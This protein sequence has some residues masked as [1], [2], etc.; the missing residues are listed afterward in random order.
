MAY[1]GNTANTQFDFN[2]IQELLITQ[3]KKSRQQFPEHIYVLPAISDNVEFQLEQ[4]LQ[5]EREDHTGKRIILIPYYLEKSHWVGILVEFQ[6]DEKIQRA[7]YINPVNGPNV[8]P[9]R[10]QKQFVKVYRYAILQPRDLFKHNDRGLSSALTIKNL[11]AAAANDQHSD[12]I[13]QEVSQLYSMIPDENKT[14]TYST[15][16]E[17]LNSPKKDNTIPTSTTHIPNEGNRYKLQELEQKFHSGLTK[18]KIKDAVMLSKEIQKTS[19]LID[20][21]EEEEKTEDMKREVNSLS[22]LEQLRNL[23]DEINILKCASPNPSPNDKPKVYEL[24]EKLNR[25]LAKINLHNMDDLVE[26]IR[27]TEKRIQIFERKGRKEKAQEEM[28]FLEELQELKELSDRITKLNINAPVSSVGHE[29]ELSELRERLNSGLAKIKLQNV[30]ELPG[31][32]KDT[33]ERVQK[34]EKR[35][36]KEKALEETEFLR[37]LGELKEILD[38][39]TKLL[40]NTPAFAPD[41]QLKHREQHDEFDSKSLKNN[42]QNT[43]EY[44]STSIPPA[45]D[46][47]EPFTVRSQWGTPTSTDRSTTTLD[48]QKK[49]LLYIKELRNEADAMPTCARKTTIE[50]LVYFEQKLLGEST[51]AHNEDTVISLLQKLKDQVKKEELLSE[52]VKSVLHDLEMYITNDN[53]SVVVRYLNELLKKF[54]SLNVPEIQRLVAK[55]KEAAE[56]IHNQDVILLIGTTGAGK[57]T[58]VQFLAGAT[59][60]EVRVEISPGKYLEHVTAVGPIKNPDLNNVNSSPL[61]KSETRYIAPVT[62]QLKDILG[63]HETGIITLYDAPGFDDKAGPEVDIA[64]SIGVIEALKG[65]KSVKLLVLSSYQSLGDRGQGIQKLAHILISMVHGIQD[66]LDAIFYAFTKYP[67]TTDI[68][69]LLLDIKRSKVDEDVTLRSDTAFVTVLSDM[70]EKTEDSAYKIE[71][72]RDEPKKLIEKLK[73]IRGIRNPEEVFRFSMSEETRASIVDHIQR[74]KF[75]IICAMKYKDNDL[76]LYY[77][78]DLQ[79]LKDLIKESFIRHT[80]EESVRFVSENISKHCTEIMEKFNRAL[81]SQDGLQ[82]KDILDYQ[83]SIKYLHQA[84][85]LK[86]HLGSSLLSPTSMLQNI[87]TE[88]NDIRRNLNEE[89][90]HSPLVTIYL[91]NLCMLKNSFTELEKN[92]SSTC[93]KFEKRFH[94]LQ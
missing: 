65:T 66:E 1:A 22:E 20:K 14:S 27:D 61:Q 38:K 21:Y 31:E 11:L 44:I 71:P 76:V 19:K 36:R 28:K 13:N 18:R 86:E 81:A 68:N 46:I 83:K 12:A 37:E 10:L 30:D 6:A 8:V 53:Y 49:K 73:N 47:G 3:L 24:Q 51:A 25:G 91:D 9:D 16:R 92:Y 79:I 62:V 34:F 58:T 59:M 72:T 82:E 63:A 77:L 50:L 93:K 48:D 39:I 33:E 57:S 26:E 85:I 70:I 74:D 87:I 80:Y 41:D 55:A 60:K 94:E 42:L 32:I 54:S 45:L 7:E 90:L 29:S 2:N 40:S 75:S 23:W 35:G 64:N 4:Q 89:E 78:N 84:Q 52:N 17:S 56:L 43:T 67:E 5:Q 69:A 15:E 88:L